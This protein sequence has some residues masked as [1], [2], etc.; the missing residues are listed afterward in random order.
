MKHLHCLLNIRQSAVA[1]AGLSCCQDESLVVSLVQRHLK[2]TGSA[3]ARRLLGDW[4]AAKGDF[5]K[6]FPHEYR[7]AIKEAAAAKVRQR[8]FSL[9][10]GGAWF[11][12]CLPP[13]CTT[14]H[15][16]VA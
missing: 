1:K 3:V 7:R 6:V 9:T 15:H 5:V 4:Q 13:A 10:L 14:T 12:S 8:L 16:A 11:W 2:Y